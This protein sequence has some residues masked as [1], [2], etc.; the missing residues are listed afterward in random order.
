MTYFNYEK[1]VKDYE[2]IEDTCLSIGYDCLWNP[3][4]HRHVEAFDKRIYFNGE[5]P[6]SF[7]DPDQKSAFRNCGRNFVGEE[8]LFSEPSDS[9][10]DF[11][12]IRQCDHNIISHI[13]SFGWWA[14]YLNP[15]KD[16]TVISPIRYHPDRPMF[17][18]REG[19]YPADW[20][21]V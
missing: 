10:M 11:C 19:F 13:S 15:K 16:K 18:H 4:V 6:C 8:Y 9:M 21:L 2:H 12:L 7:Q 1:Y 20:G 5:Q 14:A 3:E 17:T